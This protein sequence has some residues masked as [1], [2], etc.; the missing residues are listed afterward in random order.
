MV[1]IAWWFLASFRCGILDV[2]IDLL[3]DIA[4]FTLLL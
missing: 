3:L 4:V 1:P 2:V